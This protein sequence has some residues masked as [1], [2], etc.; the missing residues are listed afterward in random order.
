[1]SHE[2]LWTDK[3]TESFISKAALS[4]DDA[5]IMRTRSRGYPVS[6]QAMELHCSE[7]RI[8]K[9]IKVLKQLYDAVQKEY[10]DEFPVRKTSK[11]E[12]FM[13]EN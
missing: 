8:H 12:K 5:F 11:T 13:D 7:S 9:R 3:L 10:P 4:P 1:M 2:V 6:Y